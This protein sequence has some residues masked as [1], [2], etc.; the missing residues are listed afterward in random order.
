[1]YPLLYDDRKLK[2]K[3]VA[4]FNNVFGNQN[5]LQVPLTKFAFGIVKI[6]KSYRSQQVSFRVFCKPVDCALRVQKIKFILASAF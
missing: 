1:M 4:D 5:F 2:Q 6:M 3:L